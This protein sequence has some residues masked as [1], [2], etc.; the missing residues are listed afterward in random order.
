MNISILL[1]EWYSKEGRKLPWRETND[2]Y[3]IWISEVILQQ[4][5][6]SQG[7]DYYLRFIRRFPDIQ[8]LAKADEKE[9]LKVWEG[10]G[11]YT[12]ARNLQAAARQ[13]ESQ[14]KGKFP[15]SYS[16]II[17]LK[18]IGPY[19]AAAISSIAYNYAE[20]AIDGNV[21]R[22]VSRYFGLEGNIKDQRSEKAIRKALMKIFDRKDPGIFNQ[23]MMD[24][25]AMICKPSTPLCTN[26]PISSSCYAYSCNR[27]S[28][29]PV[30]YRKIKTRIRYFNYYIINANGSL[31]IRKRR[32]NDIWKSLYEFILQEIPEENKEEDILN[33]IS[34]RLLP[35]SEYSVN[36]SRKKISHILSHQKIIARFI[37][38]DIRSN[39]E[40][41]EISG[42]FTCPKNEIGD[43]P[44]PRLIEKYLE[45]KPLV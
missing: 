23:A 43:Y 44:F 9:V 2:P 20:P 40:I 22:V 25:G 37:H 6:I 5:R 38:I 32:E 15:V 11:Y 34:T 29:L 13:I 7:L 33:Y 28:E 42:Y 41:P 45:N 30:S 39:Q 17:N 16:D 12:R 19:T 3:K 24:L 21:K 1:K 14:H 26:C 36:I 35:G 27:V 18:G 4:T 31:Y 8:S 10:L